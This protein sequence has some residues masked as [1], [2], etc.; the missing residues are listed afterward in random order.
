[1]DTPDHPLTTTEPVGAKDNICPAPAPV[2]AQDDRKTIFF[3][4]DDVLVDYTGGYALVS[5][6][7][8]EAAG[9][10][11]KNVP[12]IFARLCPMPGALTAVKA[13][14]R[15]YE[16]HILSTAPWENPS[17]WS[18]KVYWI[19][20]HFGS[21]R[22]SPF[23]KRI[24]LTHDKGTFC[25]DYLIDDRNKHGVVRFSGLW[26]KFGSERF[27]DWPAVLAFLLPK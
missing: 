12:G 5:P 1:M 13:L 2:A 23:Y 21:D 4:M 11:L 20:R 6:A 25:G 18:D 27:P 24:N 7:E 19:F 16:C 3:D 17:A 8:L 15:Q 26:L 10:Q 22:E 9:G 14:A